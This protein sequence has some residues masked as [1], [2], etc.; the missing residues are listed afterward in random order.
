MNSISK[1]EFTFIAQK[2]GHVAINFLKLALHFDGVE[3]AEMMADPSEVLARAG[4]SLERLRSRTF[5]PAQ[6]EATRGMFRVCPT[7]I[8]FAHRQEILC[9]DVTCRSNVRS[10]LNEK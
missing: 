5:E 7:K 4:H 8:H 3:S 10:F 2:F 6:S 9:S 1:V